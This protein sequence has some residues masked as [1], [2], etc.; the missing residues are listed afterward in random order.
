MK[1]RFFLKSLGLLTTALGVGIPVI[2]SSELSV[3]ESLMKLCGTF[4]KDFQL[5]KEHKDELKMDEAYHKFLKELTSAKYNV[6]HAWMA[7]CL[8]K[9]DSHMIMYFAKTNRRE[10]FSILRNH[11][12]DVKSGKIEIGNVKEYPEKYPSSY[13]M[14]AREKKVNNLV[15][16]YEENALVLKE[17]YKQYFV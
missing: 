4:Y 11:L 17:K 7:L 3:E 10:L 2:G 6:T 9:S 1:R 15:R 5:Y 16:S 13:K 12:E 8:Y 14:T